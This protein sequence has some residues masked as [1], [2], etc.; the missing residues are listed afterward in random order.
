MK[1]QTVG[2]VAVAAIL[3][4]AAPGTAQ[5]KSWT[6]LYV[7]A[8][9]GYGFQPEDA[10]ET[11][12]F[13]KNLDG[14]FTDTVT[15]AAGANAFSPGFCGGG[16][17][18]PIPSGGCT[19]DEDGADFGGRLGY[20][21]QTGRLV[22]G[23]L[24]EGSTASVTDSVSAFSITPARYAF[25]RELS[26]LGAVRG[27]AGL[28]TDSLLVYGTGG[29]ARGSIE[30]SFNTSNA[31]NTFVRSDADSAMGFQAGAGLEYRFSK[32]SFGGEFLYTSLSDK[33]EYSV[34]VQGPAPA[35]NPFILTNPSGTDFRRSDDFKFSTVRFT[36]SY[37]F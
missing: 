6:G 33:D 35:T 25:T 29:L 27:R 17:M 7:S 21:W 13:D 1:I 9:G 10:S 16:A 14:D 36:A 31:V 32:L 24:A 22:L 5:E 18:T 20:D 11:I 12:R 15:S 34:R 3:L 28:G 37:R 8:N 4:A 19:A 30:N 23:L 2:A 26:W